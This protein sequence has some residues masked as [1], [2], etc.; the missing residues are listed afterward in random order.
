MT[1]VAEAAE[2]MGDVEGRL[3]MLTDDMIDTAGTISPPP[4]S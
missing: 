3:C 2:V 1:N 4:S